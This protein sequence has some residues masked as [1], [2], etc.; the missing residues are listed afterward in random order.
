VARSNLISGG[1]SNEGFEQVVLWYEQVP[2]YNKGIQIAMINAS[3]LSTHYQLTIQIVRQ[4]DGTNA[5]YKTFQTQQADSDGVVS[6]KYG[7][8]CGSTKNVRQ[9]YWYDGVGGPGGPDY[10]GSAYRWYIY[11]SRTAG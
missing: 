2:I 8:S 3:Y 4:S 10:T 1:Y 7:S 9:I 11:I 6:V 5:Y